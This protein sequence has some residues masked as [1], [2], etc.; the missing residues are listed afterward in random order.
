MK[1]ISDTFQSTAEGTIL[2]DEQGTV[3]LWKKAA[4]R[5]LRFR[6]NDVLAASTAFKTEEARRV[7]MVKSEEKTGEKLPLE[8]PG[9]AC[10]AARQGRPLVCALDL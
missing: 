7:I 3:V 1:E 2:A 6:A 5:L 9:S 10:S 8:Q 4:E